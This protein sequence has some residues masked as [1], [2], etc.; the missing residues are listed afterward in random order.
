[1]LTVI[2][3]IRF[4]MYIYFFVC[5]NI[6]MF[7]D[8]FVR[9]KFRPC[10]FIYIYFFILQSFSSGGALYSNHRL[11]PIRSRG[12]WR[13]YSVLL[14]FLSTW[15]E[16]LRRVLMFHVLALCSHILTLLLLFNN[17]DESLILAI[18]ATLIIAITI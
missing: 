9:I 18:T 6:Y 13:M 8:L 16:V 2:L 12:M 7:C 1:M 5:T 15:I 10:I 17:N 4:V 11:W 14:K 3:S